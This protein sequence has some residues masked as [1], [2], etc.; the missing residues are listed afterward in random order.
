[1]G[2]VRAIIFALW[3][4]GGLSQRSCRFP[5]PADGQLHNTFHFSAQFLRLAPELIFVAGY[6]ADPANILVSDHSRRAARYFIV[7]KTSVFED[8]HHRGALQRLVAM[9]RYYYDDIRFA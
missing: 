4:A 5:G 8:T 7:G 1:L 3:S 2:S 9:H 6:A